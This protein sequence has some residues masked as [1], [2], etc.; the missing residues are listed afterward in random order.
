MLIEPW[1]SLNMFPAPMGV[2]AVT[3]VIASYRQ[4]DWRCYDVFSVWGFARFNAGVHNF[5]RRRE[6]FC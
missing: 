5:K 4:V 2:C 1:V 6:F 3:R